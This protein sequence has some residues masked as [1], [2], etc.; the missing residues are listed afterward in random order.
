MP[1][2]PTMPIAEV[3]EASEE[4]ELYRRFWIGLAFTLPV[5]LLAMGEMLPGQPLAKLI[6][7]QVAG[8]L[9]LLLTTPVV[10]WSGSLFFQRGW[11]SLVHRHLNM[12]TLVSTGVGVAFLYSIV[13]LGFPDLFPASLRNAEGRVGLYFEAAAVITVLVLLGQIL[14][15]RARNQTNSALEALL[16]LAPQQA[17]RFKGDGSE[18]DVPLDRVLPGD[19]LRVRPGEKV[20]VD[21]IVLEGTSAVDE[22]MITGESIPRAKVT[23]DRV[24]GGTV[25]QTG[26]LVMKAEKVGAATLL[27]QIIHMVAEAQR[28]RAPIQRL[29]DSV[30]GYFVPAVIAIALL[31]FGLWAWLAPVSGMNYGLVNAV[32]V[33]IIACPCAL[34]LATPIS[35]MV[36]T[37]R[38]ARNGILVKNAE[39]IE[40]LEKVDTL[41][42]DKT[43]TLTEGKPRLVSIAKRNGFSEETL[44][45]LAASVERASEHPLAQAV[46][47]AARE[48]DLRM[49]EPTDFESVTGKGVSGSVDRRSVLIGTSRF[50]E[51]RG[52][53]HEDLKAEAEALRQQGQTILLVAVDG[54]AA[55]LLGV[56]DPIKES[57]ANALAALRKEGIRLVMVTGDS[58]TTATAVAAKLGVDEVH[59]ELLPQHKAEIVADYQ[60][61]GRVVAMAG[62][63]INDAPALARAEVGIA[64][65]KGT[66]VAMESAGITLIEG[67]LR[68]I[69]RARRLSRETMRNIRQNLFF[70]FAYN[71]LGIPIAAGLFFPFTGWLLNPMLAAAAMSLSSVSVIGNALRLRS[72][73][74]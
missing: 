22:S 50:L 8:W 71:S 35:I 67:D 52:I 34:G 12:F 28:S 25:N 43:G 23:G 21:G 70:A 16:N 41:L 51:E 47:N 14:E 10:L 61:R 48:R 5:F 53:V 13:A 31:T 59:A 40:T 27:S 18:E 6:P 3:A 19:R 1:L 63:G 68:A 72:V 30:S 65:G 9:Q 17:R 33:L 73:K 2:E 7:N 44:L 36:S 55:G 54:R 20:P 29:A 24:I 62:D 74:L 32:A 4:R 46:V 69:A 45:G 38:G 60:A 11:A 58:E 42:L 26:G 66:D 57:S 15:I 49:V 56:A 64:M 37:G 39:A